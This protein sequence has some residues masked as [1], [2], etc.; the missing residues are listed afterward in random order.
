MGLKLYEIDKVIQEILDAVYKYAEENEGEIP[1]DLDCLLS[2]ME[3]EREKKILDIARYIKS[4]NAEADAIKSEYAILQS[5]HRTIRNYAYRLKTYLIGS[6]HTGEKIKDSN[7]ALSWRKSEQVKITDP[8]KLS[9]DYFK[10][11][12]TPQL[13]LIKNSIKSGG[14]IDGAILVQNQNLI[15]K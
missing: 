3:V 12:R 15:I 9:D 8:T 5:R 7:T 13:T 10:I 4:M 1:D 2:K 11:E 14:S 6:L